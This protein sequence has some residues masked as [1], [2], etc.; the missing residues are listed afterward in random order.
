M[1]MFFFLQALSEY[2]ALSSP[3]C[4]PPHFYVSDKRKFEMA[5]LFRMFVG[6]WA[7]YACLI[8]YTTSSFIYLLSFSTVVASTFSVNLPLNFVGMSQ[9]N[10]SNYHFH[11]LPSHIG[12]RNAYRFCL[13]LLACVV[14]PLSLIGIKQQAAIQVIM[15]ILRFVI[16]GAL[17][18][19]VIGNLISAGDI[20]T[21]TQP[22][23]QTNNTTFLSDDD[24]VCNVTST[25]AD[26]MLHFRFEAWGALFLL[27]AVGYTVHP[28]LPVLTHPLRQKQHLGKLIH[29][30]YILFGLLYLLIGV[31]IPLWW[32]DCINE[33][34][35]LNWV[36][37]YMISKRI[38]GMTTIIIILGG[39]WNMH[40]CNVPPS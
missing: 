33:N 1:L 6:R 3:M 25:V 38:V 24:G 13:F 10:S 4:E 19:F 12:C 26:M 27:L 35:T 16:V 28:A 5:K 40:G 37:L 7:E 39:R 23:R 31:I 18:V 22:W 32:K 36:S 14:V 20:C 21:C 17:L 2:E 8:L 11:V 34:C 9:C 30:V 29:V 15:S